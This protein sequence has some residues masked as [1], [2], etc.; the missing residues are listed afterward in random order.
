MGIIATMG[1]RIG[2][3]A[4]TLALCAGM[5]PTGALATELGQ[6]AV[7]GTAG[8]ELTVQEES[9]VSHRPRLTR[10]HMHALLF[11]VHYQYYRIDEGFNPKG[12]G[13]VC[14]PSK[15]AHEGEASYVSF[16]H[17]YFND[18]TIV[19][20]DGR[21][22]Y[23]EHTYDA[24]DVGDPGYH[25]TRSTCGRK[26][27]GTYS[28]GVNPHYDDDSD[29][30]CDACGHHLVLSCAHEYGDGY[31]YDADAHWLVCTKCGEW[32][33]YS[34]HDVYD[35]DAEHQ[36]CRACDWTAKTDPSCKHEWEQKYDKD[37]HWQDC[38]KCGDEKEGSRAKHQLV[39]TPDSTNGDKSLMHY[40]ACA[41][42]LVVEGT[43]GAHLW[44]T[45]RE[46]KYT[47]DECALCHVKTSKKQIAVAEPQ[48]T[49][50][51]RI[52]SELGIESFPTVVDIAKAL[53]SGESSASVVFWIGSASEPAGEEKVTPDMQTADQG[54]MATY[55]TSG[56][57]TWEGGK[58]P[59]PTDDV[60]AGVKYEAT[61]TSGATRTYVT[62]RT[63][64]GVP[65]VESDGWER[66]QDGRWAYLRAM[67]PVR[68]EWVKWGGAW[69][70]LGA[71]AAML[72][73]WQRVNGAWYLF[74]ADGAM[75]ADVWAP[76]AGAWYYLGA[77]GAMLANT[78]HW[79]A[80]AWY[81]QGADGAMLADTTTPDGYSVDATG[82]WIA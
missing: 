74:G 19:D 39:W 72:T 47:W 82:A 63:F 46:G 33:A 75:R 38:V 35:I 12:T 41:C 21:P 36:G 45:K 16:P 57:V 2:T 30:F 59:K 73:G 15:D 51:D 18:E 79:Y 58:A 60:Y 76:Y 64:V 65:R 4:V 1:K 68:S 54:S 62:G 67:V 50:A 56:N 5:A 29:E 66:M 49:S 53:M 3:A 37:E 10:A 42:G 13:A 48:V 26:G 77:D 43:E 6:D 11:E 27:C 24:I 55:K 23:T 25:F 80:G 17:W 52:V 32:I 70:Y 44:Q 9:W 61:D 22:L 69:Y 81:Y 20:D 14:K 40:K 28:I 78:W 7:D 8:H 71:D 34:T 31:V